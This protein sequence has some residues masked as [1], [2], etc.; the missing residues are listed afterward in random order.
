ML[1]KSNIMMEYTGPIHVAGI[2]APHLLPFFA[3]EI[4]YF[5]DLEKVLAAGNKILDEDLFLA[6]TVRGMNR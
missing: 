2:D 5:G 3:N 6:V 1:I 4:H